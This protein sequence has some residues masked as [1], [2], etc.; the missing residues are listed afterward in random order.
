MRPFGEASGPASWPS[1]EGLRSVEFFFVMSDPSWE[2]GGGNK[3]NPV[4]GK[5]GGDHSSRATVTRR[6]KRP[7][8]KLRTGRPQALPYS[9]LLRMGFTWLPVLPREPVSSYLTLS[10]LPPRV[11]RRSTFCG[12]FLGV[13]PT[14]RYPASCPAEFG[15]SSRAHRAG[16]HLAPPDKSR[17]MTGN[18]KKQDLIRCFEYP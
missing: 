17:Y 18:K 6:L 8:R 16:D 9:V 2:S 12:T 14:G 3:P 4:P 5:P 11:R 1:L 10:P 15:L 13:T 7:T